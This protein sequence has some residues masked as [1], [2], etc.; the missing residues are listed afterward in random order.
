MTPTQIFSTIPPEL[1][2]EIISAADQF[3]KELYKRMLSELAKVRKTRLVA[4]QRMPRTERHPYLIAM[5]CQPPAATLALQAIA[6]WL[7]ET[8]QAMLVMFLDDLG[9]KHDGKGSVDEIPPEPDDKQRIELAVARLLR[10][11]PRLNVI[12]YLHAFCAT[13]AENWPTLKKLL[14]HKPELQL[15]ES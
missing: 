5:L 8:Q 3:D 2:L 1:S 12:I 13:V 11:H 9:I 10:F 4:I 15:S 14:E 6:N 7:L